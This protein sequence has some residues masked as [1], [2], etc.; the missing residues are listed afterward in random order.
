MCRS[1]SQLGAPAAAA[2]RPPRP[3]ALPDPRRLTV[4]LSTLVAQTF[5]L[6]IGATVM[7]AKTAQVGLG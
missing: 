5:G 2:H 4:L 3:D 6:F 7:V 1:S